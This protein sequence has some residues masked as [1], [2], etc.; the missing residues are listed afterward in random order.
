MIR[1]KPLERTLLLVLAW[2]VFPTASGY[3]Q[4]ASK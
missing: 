3:A 1:N 2:G 4:Q